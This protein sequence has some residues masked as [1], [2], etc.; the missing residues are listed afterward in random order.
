MVKG[1]GRSDYEVASEMVAA[2][3]EA[4]KMARQV[5]RAIISVGSRSV[6]G[7]ISLWHPFSAEAIRKYEHEL[8]S[9]WS[10]WPVAGFVDT[11]IRS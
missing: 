7:L 6:I 11:K 2:K 3:T 9:E 8:T 5:R 4:K 10:D 1:V